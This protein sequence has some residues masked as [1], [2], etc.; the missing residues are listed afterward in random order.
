M[1]LPFAFVLGF[2]L[3]GSLAWLARAE[4]ARSEVP[5]LLARPFHV[6]VAFGFTVFAPV[7]GY[8]LA[9]HGDW[10][11]LYLVRSARI[12][13]AVDLAL[14]LAAGA[15]VPLGFALAAPWAIAKRG[16]ALAKL[17]GVFSFV[18]LLAAVACARRLATDASFAQY[19][20]EFG[21]VPL[22]K[23]SLGRGVLLSWIAIAAAYAWS[24]RLVR[25]KTTT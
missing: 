24:L 8:F 14:A 23:S 5:L 19:H 1:P 7:A 21:M 18:L 12:P 20:G 11:Y 17:A 25:S 4:L 13:S 9:W 6:A 15:Q 16:T 10:A 2:V 22:G 3:G